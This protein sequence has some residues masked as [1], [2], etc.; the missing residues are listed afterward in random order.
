MNA[1]LERMV[2]T[3][4][5]TNDTYCIRLLTCFFEEPAMT[6]SNSFHTTV[7]SDNK[8]G[9]Q[10]LIELNADLLKRVPKDSMARL[11][12]LCLY[13]LTDFGHASFHYFVHFY[14]RNYTKTTQYS[15]DLV[16][17]VDPRVLNWKLWFIFFECSSCCRFLICWLLSSH[18]NHQLVFLRNS[19]ARVDSSDSRVQNQSPMRKRIPVVNHP[20]NRLC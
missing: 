16:N 14:S 7:F 5:S 3:S 20:I 9:F 15:H 11:N 1:A 4:P 12:S 10:I 6:E 18:H 2:W 8:W 13:L 19:K 17:G